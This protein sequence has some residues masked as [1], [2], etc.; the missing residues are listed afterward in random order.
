MR[1]VLKMPYSFRRAPVPS[2][3]SGT[4][5]SRF[6][7]SIPRRRTGTTAAIFV[8]LAGDCDGYPLFDPSFIASRAGS[9]V[10]VDAGAVGAVMLRTASNSVAESSPLSRNSVARR[11]RWSTGVPLMLINFASSDVSSPLLMR[12]RTSGSAITGLD[13]L[14]LFREDK[15]DEPALPVRLSSAGVLDAVPSTMA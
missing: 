10:V 3:I 12:T 13:S 5:P 14:P 4:S 15:D 8:G 7:V 1:L 2:L 6:G 9:V 11:S